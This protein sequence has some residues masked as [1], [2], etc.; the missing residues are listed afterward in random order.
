MRKTVIKY[1]VRMNMF[2]FCLVLSLAL[3]IIVEAAQKETDNNPTT[4]KLNKYS[5]ALFVKNQYKI[6]PTITNPSGSVQYTTKNSKI[7]TVSS[8]G[9]VTANKAGTTT[10]IVKNNAVAAKLKV[11]V[12][13][14][15]KVKN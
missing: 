2:V 10:I 8:N 7:A 5:V 11:K 14:S 1:V 6:K 4:I 9:V 3:P 12:N 15:L 13:I